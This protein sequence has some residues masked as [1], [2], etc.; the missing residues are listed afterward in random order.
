MN[1]K[2]LH[3]TVSVTNVIG[4]AIQDFNVVV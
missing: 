1:N 3:K 2:I 4:E